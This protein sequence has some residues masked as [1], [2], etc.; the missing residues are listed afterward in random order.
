MQL[1]TSPETDGSDA[2]D[3]PHLPV[4]NAFAE[5]AKQ[6]GTKVVVASGA[7]SELGRKRTAVQQLI[8]A[9]RNVGASWADLDP[10]KRQ[11]RPESEARAFFL[12]FADA[13][14]ETVFNTSNTYFGKES[15]TLRELL[16]ALRET[17]CGTLGVEYMFATDQG[18]RRWWQQR[19]EAIRSKPAFNA[20][21]KKR[22]LERLSAPKVPGSLPHT[23]SASQHLTRGDHALRRNVLHRHR[24][25]D[26][27]ARAA[28]EWRRPRGRGAGHTAGL[29]FPH[30]IL[31]GRGGGHHLLPQAGPQRAGHACADPA[32]DVQK[33]QASIPGQLRKLDP[34]WRRWATPTPSCA[35]KKPTSPAV[36]RAEEERFFETLAIGMEILDSALAGDAKLLPGDVAFKLHDTYGFPLDLSNDVARER[37]VAVD[38]AGFNA[39]M[40]QQKTQARAAGKFKMDK[41]LDYSGAANRFTGYEQLSETAKIIAIYVDGVSASAL[42]TRP[43][44]HH[45]AGYHAV[46]CRK[47]RPSGRPGRHQRRRQQL[48]RA[49]HAQNQGRRLR[50]PWRAGIR[51]PERGRHCAGRS[52][53]P[54]ARRHHAQPQRHP[55]HAQSPAR[56]A[57]QPRA[58][59]RQPWSMPTKPASTLPTNAP[60]TA[61]K[62][63]TSKPA[64]NAEILAKPAPP[65]PASWTL[66]SAQKNGRHDCVCEKYGTKCGVARHPGTSRSCAPPTWQAHLA[67]YGLA[68]KITTEGGR[69]AACAASE[70]ITGDNALAYLQTLEATAGEGRQPLKRPRTKNSP[71]A[72][73]GRSTSQS[74]GKETRPALKG[75]LASSQGDELVGQAVDVNGLKVLAAVL[76]GA[77]AKTLRDTLDKLKDKLGSAAIRAG[78]C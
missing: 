62:S 76:P 16:N 71:S 23:K 5:R 2:K 15:M 40:A 74:A 59:K 3:V 43:K 54:A 10:L 41:A 29:G 45:R 1:Q 72:F 51:Q 20:D 31:Q 60:V 64:V 26:R 48:C 65:K 58:A 12:R 55:P 37:G 25:D 53:H 34:G 67:T 24:Q 75:K 14:Q 6:G 18:Q 7:D 42:K 35:S 73:S 50:P 4:V 49:R 36:P 56:S 30:G 66:E 61:S 21:Q 69:G 57:G 32:A 38:E 22:I 78:R 27:V 11:E 52:Q 13:D 19:L 46:L 17:Y 63:A 28:R 8:A 68:F 44:R 47:R 9:Y 39:A 70:A 33:M 77:D